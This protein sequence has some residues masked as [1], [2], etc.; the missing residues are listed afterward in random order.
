M[1]I[2]R[3][4]AAL[5][6]AACLRAAPSFA[7]VSPASGEVT[8]RLDH[9]LLETIHGETRLQV[10]VAADDGTR[11]ELTLDAATERQVSRLL[12]RRVRVGGTREGAKLRVRSLLALDGPRRDD[13]PAVNSRRFITL[14]C[15][16]PDIATVPNPP[17]TYARW[18]GTGRASM[19]DFWREVS[20]GRAEVVGDGVYGWRTLPRHSDLYLYPL[21]ARAM[22]ED[23]VAAHDAEVDFSQ[24]DG[25]NIQVNKVDYDKP[26]GA[27]FLTLTLEGQSRTVASTFLI[28]WATQ[29]VYAH[30]IGH[31]FGLLHSFGAT[32]VAYESP[33]DVMAIAGAMNAETRE[34][35]SQHTLAFNKDRLGWMDA[36]RKVVP[37]AGT[38][39]TI[40]L[41]RSALAG[42]SGALL[43]EIPV[44]SEFVSYTVEARRRAGYDRNLPADAVILNRKLLADNGVPY[45]RLVSRSTNS[46]QGAMW[47]VGDTYADSL[48]GVSV[49][50]LAETADGFTVEVR[51]GYEL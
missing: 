12:G 3:I 38:R 10:Y 21:A 41:S 27:G 49:S 20:N 48:L 28:G 51:R 33:W 23:C 43:V 9:L 42:S 39:R 36:S 40:T 50:V 18:M 34:V 7:Q 22:V 1:R 29:G 14:L 47:K 26:S 25:L 6:T 15:Q 4:F 32:G 13:A 17:E 19:R 2:S 35:E 16:F 5:A 45:A 11:T 37:E 31:T 44:D 24:V 8:G 46:V 30:E